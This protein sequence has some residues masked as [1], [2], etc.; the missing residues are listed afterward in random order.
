MKPRIDI[1][2]ASPG[3]RNALGS[4]RVFVTKSGLEASLV[5]LVDLRASILNGC[6][7]CIDA[8][9]KDARA[10]GENEQRLYA[11]AAWEET[12]FF[13]ARERAALAWTD[14]LVKIGETHVSD[15][16]F[17]HAREYFSEKELV[18]LTMAIITVTAWNILATSFRIVPGSYQ[19]VKLKRLELLA[20]TPVK[21]R[22]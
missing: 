1:G 18:D 8:H 15:E 13:T 10:R 20:G 4:L 17:N 19:P 9:T 7:Y 14:E 6:A 3:A 12:P 16:A 5:D 11:I 2:T 21:A 22:Q